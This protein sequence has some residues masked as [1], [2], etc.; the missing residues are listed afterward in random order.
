MAEENQNPENPFANFR[1]DPPK[2][3]DESG[4]SEG[5]SQEAEGKS[6]KSEGKSQ[7]SEGASVDV[8]VVEASSFENVSME[9]EFQMPES[10]SE[11]LWSALAQAGITKRTIFG[12]LVFLAIII[13]GIYYLFVIQF[14]IFSRNEA[15]EIREDEEVKVEV[16][17]KNDADSNVKSNIQIG[18]SEGDEGLLAAYIFGTEYRPIEAV[19]ITYWGN[20]AGIDANFIFGSIIDVNANDLSLDLALQAK[21]ANAFNTDL[22]VYLNKSV[23]RRETLTTFLADFDQ[24][25]VDAERRS[26][27]LSEELGLLQ[28]IYDGLNSQKNEIERAYFDLIDNEK[29]Q[30]AFV[31]Y[32]LFIK[33]SN[34]MNEI[35]AQYNTKNY[36]LDRYVRFLSAIRPRIVDIRAN[37]E[38]LIKGIRVFDVQ[39]SD[40]QAIISL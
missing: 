12:F 20:T 35:K 28:S 40:I 24:M 5:K 14:D 15:N 31:N 2:V 9:D 22:Y 17:E 34:E 33:I 6:Q 27:I 4:E 10:F 21:M 32:E 26:E 29:S 38:A 23:D 16:V 36:L 18:A 3:G 25:V 19:P 11:E 39:N 7:E 30:Q 37:F 1:I 13:Y 8:E